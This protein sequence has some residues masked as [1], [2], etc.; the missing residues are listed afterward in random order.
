MEQ[1]GSWVD[2]LGACHA[3]GEE[4]GEETDQVSA[5]PPEPTGQAAKVALQHEIAKN[6]TT[7]VKKIDRLRRATLQLRQLSTRLS[8]PLKQ[9][10]TPTSRPL[11][12]SQLGL[13]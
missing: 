1:D 12:S 11:I 8:Q 9:L 3:F 10:N 4:S 6:G 7:N 13:G 5:A 2:F